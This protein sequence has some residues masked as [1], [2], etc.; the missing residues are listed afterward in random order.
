MTILDGDVAKAKLAATALLTLPGLPFVYYGEEIGMTGTKPDPRLR[1]PMQWRPGPGVGFTSGTPWAA[2]QNDAERVSVIAQEGDE[3]SLLHHYRSLIQLHVAHPALGHGDFIP[4]QTSDQ[5]VLAFLRVA[6]EETMLVVIEFGAEPAA[7]L[8]M[9][10]AESPLAGGAY[11]LQP[12]F[13]E[14]DATTLPVKEDG[15]IELTIPAI[16]P[17]SSYVFVVAS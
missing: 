14:A 9:S 16:A 2:P 7:G 13:G 17:Q 10:L 12:V 3:A 15:A 5:S 1:T 6:E 11:R 8:T 4:L